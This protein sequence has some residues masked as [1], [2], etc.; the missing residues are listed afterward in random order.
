VCDHHWG[1]Q[2][3]GCH[4]SLCFDTDKTEQIRKVLKNKK[5]ESLA[6]APGLSDLP[7]GSAPAK[8]CRAGETKAGSGEYK[9]VMKSCFHHCH[10]NYFADLNLNLGS[11]DEA[12]SNSNDGDEEEEDWDDLWQ[13]VCQHNSSSPNVAS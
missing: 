1:D 9:Y 10:P 6:K 13:G 5:A 7:A 11:D 3:S 8:W 2:K 4:Q 12:S